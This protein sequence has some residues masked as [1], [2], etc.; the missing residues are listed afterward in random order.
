MFINLLTMPIPLEWSHANKK[1][2][3]LENKICGQFKCYIYEFAII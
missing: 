2:F 3:L 1:G